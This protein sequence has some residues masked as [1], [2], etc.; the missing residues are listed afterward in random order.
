[1]RVRRRRRP[2][3]A[4]IGWV[5]EYVR[6]RCVC[7][8]SVVLIETQAMVV[9][10]MAA[11][12]SSASA[13]CRQTPQWPCPKAQARSSTMA[14]STSRRLQRTSTTQSLPS[15]LRLWWGQRHGAAVRARV[16]SARARA[17]AR[18]APVYTP[19]ASWCIR[20]GRRGTSRP[21]TSRRRPTARA[22]AAGMPRA[23]IARGMR[24]RRVPATRLEPLVR[25]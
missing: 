20:C 14:H 10:P 21:D 24:R 3:R 7:M 18:G 25:R 6:A 12:T 5:C 8:C 23:C 2:R 15:A 17:V 16:V 19:A 1:M 13:S 22:S 9:P 11:S 4:A